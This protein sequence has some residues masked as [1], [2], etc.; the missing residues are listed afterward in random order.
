VPIAVSKKVRGAAHLANKLRSLEERAFRKAAR[1]ATDDVGKDVLAEVKAR[2][3]GINRTGS[4]RKALGRKT[5]AL[6]SGAGFS[7]VVGARQDSTTRIRKSWEAV[8]AG[9]RKKGLKARFRRLVEHNGRTILV[10]PAKYLHLVEYGR[11]QVT[12]VKKKVLAD[13]SAVYGTR[14]R[15]VAGT[16]LL[17]KSWAAA[18]PRVRPY[19]VRRLREASAAAR[20]V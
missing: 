16:G 20:G 19:F 8:R 9:K 5:V 7:A 15:P 1:K 12:V 10:N 3:R 18:K 6:K 11:R 13:G 4:L 2:A 17:R 14:V